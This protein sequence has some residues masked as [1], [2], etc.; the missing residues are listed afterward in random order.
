[1]AESA[2]ALESIR[3]GAGTDDETNL[4]ALRVPDDLRQTVAKAL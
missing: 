4:A 3:L 1:M 2:T